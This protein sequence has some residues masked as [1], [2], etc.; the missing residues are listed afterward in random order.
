MKSKTGEI[1]KKANFT[2]II[3]YRIPS[4]KIIFSH[5]GYEMIRNHLSFDNIIET[6]VRQRTVKI[7]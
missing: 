2:R 4:D 6:Y 3:R 7:R 1:N 5:M